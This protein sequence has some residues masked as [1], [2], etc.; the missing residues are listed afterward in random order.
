MQNYHQATAA[1]LPFSPN[2]PDD[3]SLQMPCIGC[4]PR[5]ST[6]IVQAQYLFILSLCVIFK[7][8]EYISGIGCCNYRKNP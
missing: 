7:S 4:E 6:V 1:S 5:Q 8:S 3:C 2:V